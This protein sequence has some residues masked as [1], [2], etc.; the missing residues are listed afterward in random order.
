MF[1][2]LSNCDAELNPKNLN[3]IRI[4]FGLPAIESNISKISAA[5][6]QEP[7]DYLD[8]KLLNTYVDIEI[9]EE[10]G[11]NF[12]L[13]KSLMNL[14]CDYNDEEDLEEMDQDDSS[15]FEYELNK[16]LKTEK[17]TSK[18]QKDYEKTEEEKLFE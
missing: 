14:E 3:D 18:T 10:T 12:N 15:D 13:D 1:V 8:E 4:K 5:V 9:L 2:E 7:T 17:Q 11:E 16:S 6:K